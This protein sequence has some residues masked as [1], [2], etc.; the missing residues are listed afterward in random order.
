MV[1]LK[2][3]DFKIKRYKKSFDYSYTLGPFPTFELVLTKPETIY[4]VFIHSDFNE[5]KRLADICNKNNVAYEYNDKIFSIISNKENNYVMGVFYKYDSVIDNNRSHVLL[6]NPSDMGNLGTIIR[7]MIGFNLADIGIISPAADIFNPKTVRASMGSL[8][9]IN[10]QYFGSFDEYRQSNEN[11]EL[12]TFMLDGKTDLYNVE[13]DVENPFSL[14]F[15]SEAAGLDDSYHRHG[16][17]VKI[18]QSELVDS[19]NLSIA[20]GLGLY[21]FSKDNNI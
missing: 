7:T 5:K 9:R 10:F 11:H 13:H 1:F 8:F 6:V 12:Y 16:K 21:A 15:G 17:S 18:S 20:V 2:R 14:V 19:I 3:K 4:K